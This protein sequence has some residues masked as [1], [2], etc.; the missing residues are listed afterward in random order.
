MADEDRWKKRL[1]LGARLAL[2]L[3]VLVVVDLWVRQHTFDELAASA[4][5]AAFHFEYAEEAATTTLES[6]LERGMSA[7]YAHRKAREATGPFR[8]G[9]LTRL[10]EIEDQWIL[11]W[12]RS[13]A[14]ARE[15]FVDYAETREEQLGAISAGL[16]EVGELQVEVDASHAVA[17]A[18]F[19]DT[20]P[21]VEVSFSRSTLGVPLPRF[22]FYEAEDQIVRMFYPRESVVWEL[23]GALE[24][25]AEE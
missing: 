20:A 8:S 15:R 13:L 25:G 21:T 11:P 9:V 16:S 1:R 18:A 19:R 6:E 2:L 24:D 4:S 12:H 14:R 17:E 7:Q 5:T 22:G 10:Q 3:A 23:Q